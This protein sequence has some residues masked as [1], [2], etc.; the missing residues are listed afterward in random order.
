MEELPKYIKIVNSIS[1][2]AAPSAKKTQ[3]EDGYSA[4]SYNNTQ[5]R[6]TYDLECHV[7]SI[8]Y[9][10]LFQNWHRVN[11]KQGL[12]FFIWVN[13]KTGIKERVRMVDGQYFA[14]NETSNLD[15]AYSIKFNLENWA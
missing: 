4:V 9:L 8:D 3:F 14:T 2:S 12:R 6:T 10:I 11:L 15:G 5:M 1:F 13:P 7:C